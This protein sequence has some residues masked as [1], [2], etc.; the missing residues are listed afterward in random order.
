MFFF[1]K[2]EIQ[3][4]LKTH[5]AVSTIKSCKIFDHLRESRE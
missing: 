4:K 3:K 1:E 2:N 5:E